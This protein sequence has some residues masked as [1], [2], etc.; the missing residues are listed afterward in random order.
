MTAISELEALIMGLM[1]LTRHSAAGT[2]EHK[3]KDLIFGVP[4]EVRIYT[5]KM[6]VRSITN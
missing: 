5:S 1:W 4:T 3:L 2:E 6:Q